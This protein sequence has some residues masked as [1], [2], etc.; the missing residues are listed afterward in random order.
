MILI[1]GATGLN[2]RLTIGEF[3]REGRPVRVLVRSLSKASQAGI[4]RLPGVELFEGDM[5]K[6]EGLRAALDEV[7]RVLMISSASPDMVETQC[8]F[9]DACKRVGVR[10]VVKFSGAESGIGFDPAKFR[11][12]RMHEEIEDYLENSGVPWTHIRPSQFMQ[13]YL[14]EAP[15]IATRGVL[16][17]PFA[18]IQLSPVDAA[19]IAAVSYRLLRDGGH[20][21]ERLDMTGPE[22]L[23]MDEVAARISAAIGRK[24]A[25][26]AVTPEE[27]RLSLLAHGVPPGFADALDEQT[28]ER[29]KRPEARVYLG[30]HEAFG[31]RATTFAEFAERHRNVF[32]GDS[33]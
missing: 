33:A 4:D 11:F 7:E 17:L 26:V 18:G 23:T 21:G 9:I 14:R 27:R 24:V 20:I 31:V 29:L 10:H 25:Y 3:A 5:S 32:R 13:V 30:T 2:G 19:D 6:A 15:D 22:A 16:R 28:A 12:M 8:C 1:T